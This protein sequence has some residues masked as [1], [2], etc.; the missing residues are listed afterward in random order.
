MPLSPPYKEE[1]N[2]LNPEQRL[3]VDHLEGPMMVFA[4][5]G[6][7]KTQI[8]AMRIANILQSTQMQ[9]QNILCLTFTESGVVA[10]RKRLLKIIGSPAY[11]V[12]IHTF[13]S[14]CNDVIKDHPEAFLFKRE[15]EALTEVER[16]QLIQ[17]LLDKQPPN[18][19]LTPFAAPYFYQ[20]DVLS[21]IQQLKRENINPETFESLLKALEAFFKEKGEA[22]QDFTSKH[23]RSLTQADIESARTLLEG[24]PLHFL[25]ADYPGELEPK[26][27]TAFKNEVKKSAESLEKQ[28]SKQ[29]ALNALYKAYQKALFERGRYDFEDMILFVVRAFEEK[30]D[31]LAEY[32][33]QFQYILVDEYQD[34]NGAQNRVV[35]LI[36]NYFE[37]PNVFVVGDDKQSIYRF[38]GAS[39]ENMLYFYNLYKKSVQLVSLKTNYR[40]QQGVL[41]AAHT[42]IQNNE[43]GL[44]HYLPEI[45]QELTAHDQSPPKK[46]KL[47]SLETQSAEHYFI[48]KSIQKIIQKGTSPSEIAVLYRNNWEAQELADLL[49]RLEVPFKLEAGQDILK[50]LQIKQLIDLLRVIHDPEDE[51]RLFQVLHYEFLNF[52]PLNIFKL[53]RQARQNRSSLLESMLAEDS[54][55]QSFAQNWMAWRKH[56]MNLPF[57]QFLD[58]VVKESGY[59]GFIMS[60][61]K[62]VE[63]LNRLNSFFEEVKTLNRAK[64]DLNLESALE[65]L[66]LL[67]ENNIAIKEQPLSTQKIGVRL[68]T[69]H[70]SKGLEFD[71]VFI[72][73]MVDK[74]WGNIRRWEKL[75]L[76]PG[77]LKTAQ[78]TEKQKN[79]DERRL[80]YVALTRAKKEAI[81]SY[82]QQN[83]QGRP[84]VPSLFIEEIKEHTENLDLARFE[85]EAKPRLETIFIT[86]P[87]ASVSEEEKSF[88]G[89]LLEN[90]T[91]SVTHLN[92]YLH[93][94]RRF[95]YQNLL[96][97]PGAKNKHAAFGTAVHESLKDLSLQIKNEGQASKAYLLERFEK[98]MQREIL[99]HQEFRG[100]LELGKESLGDYF[101]AHKDQLSPKVLP[102]YDFS[103][104]GVNLDGIP[105][106][107]KLDKI[108]IL[109]EAAKTVHVV[110]Y[111]TGN[112]DTKSEALKPNGDYHRQ[113]VFYQLLCDL[114]PKFPYTMVSG[115]ID[116][117]QKSKRKDQFHR[118]R[119]KISK[120]ELDV[121]K[122]E[123]KSTY[124]EIMALEFADPN[125]L[126][127]CGECDYCLIAQ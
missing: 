27:R 49:L 118:Q 45:D 88:I 71:Y 112:P 74:H 9:P 23:G 81:L 97:V 30:P 24:T 102:E 84:Q 111:K 41:D 3:A 1:Y 120:E 80:F 117:V 60:Q 65:H 70:K 29:F 12:R 10:M 7:G 32:Q 78:L 13:H 126:S 66:S 114:S 75:P 50:D 34:T 124:E 22:L 99:T 38:Q 77:L 52:T 26:Q 15:L 107:G 109:D 61:P 103:S 121:L 101:E 90:Y 44:H 37:Q 5:P 93:C 48:A 104:H 33:E 8:I 125:N 18:G 64:H 91:M 95:Y 2:R 105:L 119:Y 21:A 58:H 54:P 35:E 31:L 98:H 19:L 73:N 86:P 108:E 14:F 17:E 42:L 53:V 36:S 40:S 113:M 92:N 85:E 25:I 67:E 100:G 72:M 94:P 76:P 106:T 59:L 20:K 69:A 87:K 46:C 122:Q 110:D 62:K 39:M 116:F 11:H 96:R 63:H 57:V 51:G 6:T 4:G 82:S 55:F 127:H 16:I 56:S 28:L 79:E 68:M 43:H 89:S 115:E 123:I 83:S 47:A